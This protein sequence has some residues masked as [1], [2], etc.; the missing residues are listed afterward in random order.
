MSDRRPALIKVNA[1]A[2]ELGLNPRLVRTLV[3]RG[4]LRAVRVGKDMFIPSEALE[5]FLADLPAWSRVS[6]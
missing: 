6:A 5:R 4:E 3:H 2:D 1:A